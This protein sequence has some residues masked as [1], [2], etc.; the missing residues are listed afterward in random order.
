M[1]KIVMV[2]FL[3]SILLLV[4]C[5]AAFTLPIN[6]S[7]QKEL[8][9][10]ISKEHLSVKQTLEEILTDIE[11]SN[12]ELHVSTVEFI[13]DEQ[14]S[15]NF[16]VGEE[17]VVDTDSWQWIVD[18][19]GWVYITTDNVVTLFNKGNYI[20]TVFSAKTAMLYG[21]YQSLLY[22]KETWQLF[23]NNPQI[24]TLIDFVNAVAAIASLTVAIIEDATDG[25]QEL[26]NALTDFQNEVQDFLVFLNNE[27]WKAPILIYGMVDGIS[28]SAEISCNDN[29]VTTMNT[30]NLSVPTE[31]TAMP[32]WIHKLDISATYD[33][34][35]K[36]QS[37]YAFSMGKIEANFDFS[38]EKTE[39]LVIR[40]SLLH[41]LHQSYQRIFHFCNRICI[42]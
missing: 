32:W 22:L 18:R 38:T 4:P 25:D 29:S 6:K 37:S 24:M 11:Q 14:Y 3:T 27:P 36:T 1:K 2:I 5:T 30:Y 26:I 9:Q 40:P 28:T 7:E 20:F 13:L 34:R 39:Q 19:L 15:S 23:K 35:Q 31:N 16:Q 12:G 42:H 17:S 10:L 33:S 41:S 21:W 8:Q